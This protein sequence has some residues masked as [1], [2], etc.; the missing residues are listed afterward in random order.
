MT[1]PIDYV[2][3][4]TEL[5]DILQRLQSDETDIDTSLKLYERGVKIAKELET[6][7]KQAENTISKVKA[8]LGK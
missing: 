4:Q 1:K 3:L 2:A 8:D 7:L 5:D 6:Y